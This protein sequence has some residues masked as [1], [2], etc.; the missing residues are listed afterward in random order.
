MLDA[1]QVV[2]VVGAAAILIGFGLSQ[3]KLSRTDDLSYLL[4]NLAG[5]VLLL[6]S[7]SVEEQWG[8]IILEIAWS[9]IS[10]WSLVGRLR[11]GR[12]VA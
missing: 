6:I 5:G 3:F 7:A 12:T 4:L 1:A 11:A 2:Q 10:A 9:S 8:F